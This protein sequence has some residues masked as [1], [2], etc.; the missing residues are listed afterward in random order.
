MADAR[1][2]IFFEDL[3]VGRTYRTDSVEVTAAEIASFAERYDPQPMHLDPVAARQSVFGGLVASGWMTAALTMRL[4]VLGEFHLGT[5][6][7]GLG[8]DTLQWP[9][10]VR[11]GDRLTATVEVIAVRPSTSKPR[12][13]LAKIRTTTANQNGEPVQ[14]MVS[15]VLLPRR[16]VE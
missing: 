1:T 5:G 8:V 10:P 15:N 14:V 13:G 16:P 9:R 11:A 3:T 2:P 6:V 12:F 7:V 4:M